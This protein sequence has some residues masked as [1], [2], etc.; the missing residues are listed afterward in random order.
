MVRENKYMK[1]VMMGNDYKRVVSGRVTALEWEGV[2][3]VR[4]MM[5]VMAK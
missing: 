4:V 3:G 5:G 1:K 2:R